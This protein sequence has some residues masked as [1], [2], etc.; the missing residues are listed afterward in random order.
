MPVCFVE[1]FPSTP[2]TALSGLSTSRPDPAGSEDSLLSGSCLYDTTGAALSTDGATPEHDC[3]FASYI[4]IKVL[5]EWS[6]A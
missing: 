3:I 6:W 1:E 4:L 2:V 5:K